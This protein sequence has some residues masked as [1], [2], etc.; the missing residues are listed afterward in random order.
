VIFS[1]VF[2]YCCVLCVCFYVRVHIFIYANGH[3][4]VYALVDLCRCAD[5]RLTFNAFLNS[6]L[7]SLFVL[8]CLAEDHIKTLKMLS[9]YLT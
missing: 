5:M 2:T 1:A 9:R 8:T 7:P 3:I 6:S 4:S